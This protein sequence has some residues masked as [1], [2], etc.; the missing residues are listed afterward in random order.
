MFGRLR[1]LNTFYGFP[2][3]TKAFIVGEVIDN[4]NEPINGNEYF[5]FSTITEF[6]YSNSISR[7]FRGHD[8]LRWLGNF[9]EGWGF[10][11]SRYV[12]TFVENHDNGRCMLSKIF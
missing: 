4:G 10:H 5:G 8:A 2:A 9:G 3:N 11:P 6:R 12:L 1:N 7:S